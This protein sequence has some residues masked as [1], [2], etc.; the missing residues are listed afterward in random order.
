M[1]STRDDSVAERQIA[2]ELSSLARKAE[3]GP[4]VQPTMETSRAPAAN[5]Q[6]T[7][8]HLV[9]F[10]CSLLAVSFAVW[11][12][13]SS[14]AQTAIRPPSDPAPLTRGTRE[15]AA[16]KDGAPSAIALASELTQQLQSMTRDLAALRQTVEQ[17]NA[18]QEKLVH[19]N[20]NVARQ[21]KTDQ[22]ELA[23]NNRIIDDVKEIQIQMA[24]ESQTLTDRLNANQ[25]QLARATAHAS[26]PKEMMPEATNA[27]PENPKVM[28]EV[29]L[30]RPRQ[31]AN[32]AQAP[33]PA[34]IARPQAIKPQ[35]SLVWPWSR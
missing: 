25:E 24:R 17:L 5:H 33:K 6:S 7:K 8:Q 2:E 10:V 16:Q 1:A 19:D 30:P 14:S 20:E 32:N 35:P 29:P 11:W 18:T 34:S 23:R 12:W 3:D 22:E 21:L 26:A 13:W 31:S 9:A 4:W 28:Q 15:A 27:I